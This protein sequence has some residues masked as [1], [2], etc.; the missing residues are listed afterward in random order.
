MSINNNPLV[1]NSG[2]NIPIRKRIEEFSLMQ[3]KLSKLEEL[4]SDLIFFKEYK[5]SQSQFLITKKLCSDPDLQIEMYGHTSEY[6][7]MKIYLKKKI[8]IVVDYNSLS[9]AFEQVIYT[10]PMEIIPITYI[11]ENTFDSKY[12]ISNY[13]QQLQNIRNDINSILFNT[14]VCPYNSKDRL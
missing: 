6:S 10:N 12:V 4:Y 1:L 7:T 2:E 5:N 8:Q 9:L 3:L 11:R 14:L 13:E